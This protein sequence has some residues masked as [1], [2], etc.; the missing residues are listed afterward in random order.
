MKTRQLA[1]FAVL[2]AL[3]VAMSAPA[4]AEVSVG[5]SISNAPPPPV[6]VYRSEPHTVFV[7]DADVY[8]VD[9]PRCDYDYFHVGTYW[10]IYNGGYWYRGRG[11]RGPFIAVEQRVVPAGI[12][13]VPDQRWRHHPHGGPPGLM[14]KRDVVVVRDERGRG[15]DHDDRGEHGHGHGHGHDRD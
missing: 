12:W 13:R 9:D 10:Y 6:V 15:R 8:Y 14:R 4:R 7:R 5:I 1:G 3:S 2:A 11:Y